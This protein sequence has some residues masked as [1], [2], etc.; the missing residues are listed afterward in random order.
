MTPRLG[1]L[2][3]LFGL[4]AGALW[5]DEADLRIRNRLAVQTAMLKGADLVKAGRFEEAVRLLEPQVPYIDGNGRFL[6]LLR[7][8]YR[9]HVEELA[10]AGKAAEAARYRNRLAILDPG[11][12]YVVEPLAKS[13]SLPEQPVPVVDKAPLVGRGK[14]F[15]E[16]DPFDPRNV[17]DTGALARAEKAFTDGRFDEAA[18]AYE[19]I[20]GDTLPAEARERWAYCKLYAVAKAMEKGPPPAGAERAIADALALSK[21]PKLKAWGEGLLRKAGE[22]AAVEV[23]HTAARGDGWALAE[24]ANFRVH[25]RTTPEQAEKAVRVA[26]AARVRMARFWFGE[27]PG[28][29]SPRCDVFLHPSAQAFARN[30]GERETAPGFSNIKLEGGR[31]T[32]RG[33]H[34][35]ADHA[36]VLGATLPHETT[37]VVIA[38]RFGTH[39]VPRWADEGIAVL[40]EPSE[41][42]RLHLSHLPAHRREGRLLPLAT[43]MKLEQYPDARLVGAFYAQSVS[44]TDFLVK[45]R[46]GVTF[47][48]F[49][50]AGLEGGY[51]GAL[52]RYYGYKSFADLERDWL[53]TAFTGDAV[54]TKAERRPAR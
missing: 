1:A 43:L 53:A 11:T 44:V 17:R 8:A 31:V 22:G 14:A 32:E 21:A 20:N 16:L 7:D 15:A 12:R 2:V 5:A 18:A 6:D 30:T 19:A 48:R 23:K 10:K 50:R 35:R 13:R 29:W 37:H 49:V 24:T 36:N 47:T 27:E 54:A 46:D 39:H 38:G 51:E 28:D 40:S 4:C 42:V 45:K 41:Q 26:E 25:H 9:G 34:V 33:I 52:E 3:A